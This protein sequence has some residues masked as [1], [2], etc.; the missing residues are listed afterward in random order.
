MNCILFQ[1]SC[2][3]VAASP[4]ALLGRRKQEILKLNYEIHLQK[5]MHKDRKLWYDPT[6]R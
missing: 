3:S 1:I 4:E 5:E 2:P 6:K